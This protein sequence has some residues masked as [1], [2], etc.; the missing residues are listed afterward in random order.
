[1]PAALAYGLADLSHPGDEACLSLSHVFKTH[2]DVASSDTSLAN[3][4]PACILS[5]PKRSSK[6]HHQLGALPPHLC[7]TQQLTSP[8]STPPLLKGCL[9]VAYQWTDRLFIL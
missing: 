1:M 3:S 7:A 9:P 4:S 8:A 5:A 2:M 6:I